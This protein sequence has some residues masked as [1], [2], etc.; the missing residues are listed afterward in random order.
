MTNVSANAEVTPMD[1]QARGPL[2][3]LIGSGLLWLI[4]SGV[5]AVITSIQV[6]SPGFLADCSVLTYGRAQALRETAFI[7]GWLGNTGLAVVLWVLGR[8]GGSPLRAL[9][10]AIA[11]TIFWNLGI[12]IG[13]VG[14]GMGDMTGVPGMQL[15]RYVQGLLLLAYAAIAVPG[16]LAWSGRR[17]D[18]TYASHWYGVAAL[19]L[20]PWLFSVAQIVL[21]WSPMRG[22]VQAVGAN[23]FAQSLWSLWI[24]PVALTA[25]YYIVPKVAGRLMPSYDFALLGFWTLVFI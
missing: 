2:F 20:F 1:A 3:L 4:I 24:A 12:T 5:L 6:H 19:F 14:I 22:T 13:L 8:L 15:P 16:V 11:G 10:W 21:L 23:W 17:T 9:N 7:Y 18:G 25:A